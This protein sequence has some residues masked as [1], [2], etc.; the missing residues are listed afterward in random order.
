MGFLM[1]SQ[2]KKILFL[3]FPF[4][5]L[6]V[7]FLVI[8]LLSNIESDPLDTI[9]TTRQLVI[10]LYIFVGFSFIPGFLQLSFQNSSP[11]LV[12]N[13]S[14]HS[15]SL[16][17][18]ELVYK[19]RSICTGCLGSVISVLLGNSFLLL[20]FFLP[21]FFHTIN[22]PALLIIG[23]ILILVTFSRYFTK[24]SARIRLMQHS[25]LFF[26]ISFLIIAEDIVFQS[27]FF[28]VL[29]LPSWISIL[30]VRMKLSEDNHRSN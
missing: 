15:G 8:T 26:G 12:V 1:N 13:L 2:P 23:F 29:L 24:F 6:L 14:H 7:S 3:L 17:I 5:V 9:W 25:A 27:A 22:V 30:L 11:W 18:H 19:N 21:S 16:K 20:Y 4:I 10:G 28:I